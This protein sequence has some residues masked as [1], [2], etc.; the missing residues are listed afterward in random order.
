MFGLKF[1]VIKLKKK[2][3]VIIFIVLDPMNQE[4]EG[5]SDNAAVL[6]W[7]DASPAC[8]GTVGNVQSSGAQTCASALSLFPDFSLIHVRFYLV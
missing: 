6:G 5:P 7:A 3:K 8:T 2:F 4:K 1:N